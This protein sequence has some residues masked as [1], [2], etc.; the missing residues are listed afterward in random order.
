MIFYILKAVTSTFHIFTIN[1]I[2]FVKFHNWFFKI[3]LLSFL[4]AFIWFLMVLLKK[5]KRNFLIKY[6]QNNF[7][8]IACKI[9][10][11]RNFLMQ[12]KLLE[13]IMWTIKKRSWYTGIYWTIK[14]SRVYISKSILLK[15]NNYLFY[16]QKMINI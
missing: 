1:L 3:I 7:I 2:Y 5:Y 14:K 6:W 10:K 9:N 4:Q 12:L 8:F 16:L 13:Y 15:E 11:K